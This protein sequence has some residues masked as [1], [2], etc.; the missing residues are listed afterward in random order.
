M[1]DIS[2]KREHIIFHL[3]C[4]S[5]HEKLSSLIIQSVNEPNL[6][7]QWRHE[8]V[9]GQVTTG[10]NY[11][12]IESFTNLQFLLIIVER[13]TQRGNGSLQIIDT[14]IEIDGEFTLR[15]SQDKEALFK[16]IAVIHHTGRVN[17][18]SRNTS[19]HYQADILDTETDLWYQTSDED[20]PFL[21]DT[22][23]DQGYIIILKKV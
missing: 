14:Q 2:S 9:C 16:P 22:P 20:L 23:S 7:T 11:R 6:V 8:G 18:G 4:P 19:G 12:K 13:L 1:P 17:E 5:N 15:D 3:D 21:V 10:F